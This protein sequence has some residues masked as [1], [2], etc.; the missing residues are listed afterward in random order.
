MFLKCLGI[1]IPWVSFLIAVCKRL[2]RCFCVNLDIKT[3]RFHF[4][5]TM[6]CW[7]MI[8]YLKTGRIVDLMAF[9][10]E[11]INCAS[12]FL[13]ITCKKSHPIV[14]IKAHKLHCFAKGFSR[15]NSHRSQVNILGAFYSS[16]GN[17]EGVKI[18]TCLRATSLQEHCSK[19][20]NILWK[21]NWSKLEFVNL[22]S[23][24]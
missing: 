11:I 20:T 8:N 12:V 23:S 2:V 14:K 10:T 9:K 1:A 15:W 3:F 7:F 21:I 16:K 17:I 13:C 6:P 18:Q 4:K 19:K 5:E 22:S 24:F